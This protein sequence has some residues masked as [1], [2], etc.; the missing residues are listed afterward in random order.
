MS[1][2]ADVEAQIDPTASIARG[3]QLARGVR[4]GAFAR[5]AAGAVLGECCEVA[6]H[7]SISAG[8][9]VA[10]RVIVRSGA[11]LEGQLAIES[12]VSIGPN[13]VVGSRAMDVDDSAGSGAPTVVKQSA[14]VGANAT[15][16]GGVTIGQRAVVADGSVVTKNVPP[17]A[18][19]LGNP[20]QIQTYVDMQAPSAQPAREH[21]Y[22]SDEHVTLSRVRGVKLYRLPLITDLRGNLSVAEFEHDLPFTPRRYFVTFE[23][24][25]A[26]VRGEHAHREQHQFLAC[27]NGSCAVVVDDGDHREEYVLDMPNLGLYLPPLVWA[28]QYKHVRDSVLLVLAS[29]EYDPAD[30]IRDYDEYLSIVKAAP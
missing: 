13:A 22:V 27:L 4:V 23:V 24:P 3:A 28:T 17:H 9:I 19:V 1:R 6:D 20:A 18:I 16:R 10:D 2:S 8:T 29:A 21:E 7:V 15:V 25:N 11:R 14:T 26:E 30:Y 5:I 12:D